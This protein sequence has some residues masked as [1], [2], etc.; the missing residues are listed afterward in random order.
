MWKRWRRRKKDQSY[1]QCAQPEWALE[2]WESNRRICCVGV[3]EA[4][5][6]STE[7]EPN[8]RLELNVEKQTKRVTVN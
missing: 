6:G 7:G 1:L 2:G 4:G 5:K 8:V 3:P